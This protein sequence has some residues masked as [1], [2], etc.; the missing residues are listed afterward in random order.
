MKLEAH[1]LH[2]SIRREPDEVYR[3]LAKPENLP[4][5]AAGLGSSFRRGP[6]GWIA[7]TP[8]GP[9]K[10]RFEAPNALRVADHF[11][12]PAKGAEVHIPIRVLAHDSGSEVIFTLF[13]QPGMSAENFQEDA[14]RVREDLKSLKRVLEHLP[15]R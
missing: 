12:M 9:V 8:N 13:P 6:D 14:R 15:A 2:V 11:V 7:E 3:F 10:V 1:T 5:W 4:Q